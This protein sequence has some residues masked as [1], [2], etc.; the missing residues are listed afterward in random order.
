MK[1]LRV[2][3]FFTCSRLL[4]L[5]NRK[6]FRLI[7]QFLI[8]YNFSKMGP[9]YMYSYGVRNNASPTSISWYAALSCKPGRP[10]TRGG[11]GV[12]Q[13]TRTDMQE[14]HRVVWKNGFV[15]H[16]DNTPS[17]IVYICLNFWQKSSLSV[18]EQ[19]LHSPD[20]APTNFFPFPILKEVIKGQ[21]LGTIMGIKAESSLVLKEI[22]AED[23]QLC[24]H[25]WCTS[26]F[27]LL[28]TTLKGDHIDVDEIQYFLNCV[29]ANFIVRLLPREHKTDG[30]SRMS[31][32]L[33]PVW[34]NISKA[35][36]ILF[37]NSLFIITATEEI[38]NYF[39]SN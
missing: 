20:L 8:F 39:Y 6:I 17:Y 3:I 11:H 38:Q 25:A 22:P 35:S 19:S 14:M 18:F 2:V 27:V 33:F 29:V 1:Q 28:E 9:F 36:T 5:S 4:S 37:S 16:R 31:M 15:I 34:S 32:V 10:V 26:A 30:T 21:H 12:M 24:F 7:I 23:Y 13:S